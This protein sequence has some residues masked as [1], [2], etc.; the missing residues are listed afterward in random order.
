MTSQ[1]AET[2][3]PLTCACGAINFRNCLR[4]SRELRA[5]Y[6]RSVREL[7]GQSRPLTRSQ[8]GQVREQVRYLVSDERGA[9]AARATDLPEAASKSLTEALVAAMFRDPAAAEGAIRAA[10]ARYA[11]RSRR[12]A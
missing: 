12:A 10:R 6:K 4:V 9:F 2:T 3:R 7:F 1:T 8:L 5:D 11:L